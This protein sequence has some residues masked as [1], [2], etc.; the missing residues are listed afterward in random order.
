MVTVEG[1]GN[2]HG[3]VSAAKALTTTRERIATGLTDW[4]E[5]LSGG[6]VP[7][8]SSLFFGPPGTGKSTEA[9]R[10]AGAV[11]QRRNTKALVLSCEMTDD[12]LAAYCQRLELPLE[13]IDLWHEP[14]WRVARRAIG[15]SYRVIVVDS[16]QPYLARG[17]RLE[18]L[19]DDLSAA[20]HAVRL[21]IARVNSKGNPSGTVDLSH[22]V[23]AVIRLS[24]KAIDV[25]KSRYCPI[26]TALR[27]SSKSDSR[28]GS[29]VRRS[30]RP[31]HLR[32][33]K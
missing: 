8:T 26:G 3:P 14:S 6:V 10:I 7:G 17:V 19:L 11:A 23:D 31:R 21:L 27:V 15:P 16:V 28:R 2:G 32:P 1:G 29:A 25:E 22:D 5:V 9:L 18:R 13:R 20:R 33:A 30:G 24:P 4:D 12:L